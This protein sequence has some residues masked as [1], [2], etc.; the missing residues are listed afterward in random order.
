MQTVGNYPDLATAKL[1]QSL[2]DAEGIG[3][4]V[5]DEFLAGVD[6]QMGTALHGVRL[7]VAPE[8]ADEARALLATLEVEPDEEASGAPQCP[9]CGSTSI[10]QARWKHRLK[11]ATLFIP[12]LLVFWPV[13]AFIKPGMRCEKCAFRWK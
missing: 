8:D 4:V 5:P 1:A 2:L 6:W 11:A 12:L 3:S 7:Q 13:I 9:S 10:H